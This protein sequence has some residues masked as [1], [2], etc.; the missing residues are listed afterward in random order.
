[1]AW[2]RVCATVQSRLAGFDPD[3]GPWHPVRV[4]TPKR[5]SV[6]EFAHP[7]MLLGLLLALVPVAVH[8]FGRRKAPVVHFSA[9]AF[10]LAANPKKARAL[11]VTEWLLVA[12][13][14]LAV[15]LVALALAR[16]ML[17]VPGG[18]AVGL[19]GSEGPV[20]VVVVL[21]D[22]MSTYA[23]SGGEPL[24][25]R[26]RARAIA[27][28]ERLP[29]GSKVAAVASGFPAR[30]LV[31]QA[32]VDRGAVL[33]AVRRL[34]HHPRRDDAGRALQLADALMGTADLDDRRVVVLT[35]F[36][37]SGWQGASPPWLG[38]KDPERRPILLRLDRLDPDTRENTAITD[39]VATPAA[40][41]GP[42]QVRVEVALQ[43]YGQKPFRGYLTVR[44][45]D[46]EVKSL[47]QLQPGEATRRSFVLP[48][49]APV[50]EILLPP[51]GLD[52]D[53]RRLL[54]LDGG[55]AVRV[56]LVDGA[57][58]PVPR[59]DEVFFAARALELS[60]SHPGELAVDVLQLPGM[61]VQS[62]KDYDVV[63]L[64]NV[65][66]LPA[67]V[68]RGI[69]QA[70]DGGKGVLITV[71]DNLPADLT[72]FL[73]GLLPAPLYGQRVAAQAGGSGPSGHG[74]QTL[75]VADARPEAPVPGAVQRL[76]A[77]LAPLSDAL[78]QT[79]VSR[80]AL[81]Q[82]SASVSPEIVMTY[83][84]GAPALLLQP[85]G[86]GLVALLTTTLDR[87][88]TDLPLQ[89]GFLPLLHDV[90]VGLA[91]ERGLER[92]SAVEIGEVAV[93]SRD[94]RADQLELRMEPPGTAQRVVA[95]AGTQRGRGWQ[96]GGLQEP[97]RYTA[98]ELRGGVALTSRTLIVVP[99]ATESNLAVAHGGA[100][101]SPGQGGK[102]G[103][104]VV[105]KAPGW[106]AVLVVLLAL[107]LFE[108]LVLVRG[109]FR[110]KPEGVV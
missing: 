36:Q 29:T 79:S 59:E 42:G 38:R 78:G 92:R 96:I 35:D 82:P 41:R 62:L 55:A 109:S 95:D 49:S 25:E 39:A 108:G 101:G 80:Y 93:L 53:N 26:A 99:P 71:G 81:V 16:P 88:W 15:A 110:G 97:G 91:G 77:S 34:E 58:R 10:I 14:S 52:A 69:A 75:R 4:S 1:M 9:L 86:H 70:V 11:R 76:R 17:P 22:S 31:R 3:R 7:W 107:L 21:D 47:V 44:A 63:V 5:P 68:V 19:E 105:P 50:A 102:A 33:D 73:P 103:A 57:P 8:L 60:A 85:R 104:R 94:D 12:L 27:L 67:E 40:D 13:R 98:T 106:S 32:T 37:A 74:A 23:R 65:G 46:R 51:D 90:A 84:D 6:I 72:T 18:V 87:D 43:H 28:I 20:A 61:T 24:F 100:L 48:A 54:R 89:P 83:A 64:A 66:E 56:A 2:L 30:L 45:G